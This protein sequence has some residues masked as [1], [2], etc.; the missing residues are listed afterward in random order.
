MKRPLIVL[1]ALVALGAT[2]AP[3][4]AQSLSI[5]Y[6]DLDLS[7]EQ[8]QKALDRRIDSA[9]RKYC[10]TNERITGTRISASESRECYAETMK[11]AKAQ[12]AAVVDEQRVGG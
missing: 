3:A 12:F 9:V 10:G 2:A 6:R 1:A 11:Q 7:T 5:S 4:Y 8:G